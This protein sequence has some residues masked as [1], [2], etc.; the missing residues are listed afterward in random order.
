[1]NCV[2]TGARILNR[3]RIMNEPEIPLRIALID[4]PRASSSLCSE[5]AP[6]WLRQFDPQVPQSA[7]TLRLV[8]LS[9][10]TIET[11][12]FRGPFVQGRPGSRFVYVNSGTYAGDQKSCWSRRAKV[13]LTGIAASLARSFRRRR[14][15]VSKQSFMEPPETV[16]PLVAQ[17]R[18]SKRSG[19]SRSRATIAGCVLERG[20]SANT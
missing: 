18:F 2:P 17:S 20:I 1:M 6:S 10:L 14:R 19:A 11:L 5:A 9:L 8:W 16:D 12:I 15:H 4:A 7:S 3:A 13:P